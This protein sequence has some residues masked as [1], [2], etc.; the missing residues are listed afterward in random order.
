MPTLQKKSCI[1]ILCAVT[2]AMII[3][4]C[5]LPRFGQSA[6]YHMFS[7]TRGLY[8]VPNFF[9]VASNGGLLAVGIVGLVLLI[10]RPKVFV[11][12]YSRERWPYGMFFAGV[13]LTGIG[14]SWY[15]LVPSNHTL[16]WDRF[17]MAIIFAAFLSITIMERISVTAGVISVFPCALIGISTV[18]YWYATEVN[19]C[20]DL[21]PYAFMQFYPMVGIPLAMALMPRR[22]TGSGYLLLLI[23]IYGCAKLLEVYDTQVYLHLRAVSGHT[24][25]H[26]A[27]AIALIPLFAMLRFREYTKRKE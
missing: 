27:A 22:Y 13:L 26:A 20:G 16:L 6:E 17:P 12:E 15:H 23:G 21:R 11:F 9:D 19:G 10:F 14:S 7:D 8:G 24:L 4:T 18:I 5:L 1:T 2:V 25:K 3:I